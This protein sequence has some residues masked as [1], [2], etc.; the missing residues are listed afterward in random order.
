[1]SK[2]SEI[3][4]PGKTGKQ[5]ITQ[6]ITRNLNK[7]GEI[8]G[9]NKK[10]TK[11]LRSMCCHHKYTKKGKLRPAIYN[12]GNGVCTCELCGQKFTTHLASGE[13]IKEVTGNFMQYVNQSKYATVAA[14]LGKDT[15]T[16]L[17]KMSVDV[18][19]FPKVYG[20]INKAIEKK[21]KTKKRKNKNKRGL[22]SDSDSYGSWR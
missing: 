2:N 20:R 14:S 11:N 21:E 17:A 1:M 6:L 22:T 3:Q 18:N 12:D 15:E 13:E 5:S 16:Y 7:H 19:H 10:E 4:I 9:K 8:K